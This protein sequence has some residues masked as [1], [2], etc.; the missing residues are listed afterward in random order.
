MQKDGFS[1]GVLTEPIGTLLAAGHDTTSLT[2]ASAAGVLS[3]LEID[4]VQEQRSFQVI[5]QPEAC[6]HF[7]TSATVWR[8][9]VA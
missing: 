7:K 6:L 3:R 1:A 5:F 4:P 9:W 8:S 2:T